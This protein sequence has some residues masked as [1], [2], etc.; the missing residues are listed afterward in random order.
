MR[1][2]LGFQISAACSVFEN[3]PSCSKADGTAGLESRI[4]WDFDSRHLYCEQ[5]PFTAA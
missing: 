5:A 1:S 2:I 4:S 3:G